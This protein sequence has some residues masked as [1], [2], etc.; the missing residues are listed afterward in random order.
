M[1]RALINKTF[2]IRDGEI[3]ISFLMQL[4]IFTI[5]TVLLMVKPT[6]NALFLSNLGADN[7]P[8]GYLLVAFVAV[9]TTYFYNKLVKRFS[10]LKI[11]SISLVIFSVSFLVLSAVLD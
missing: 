3:Y 5:I 1:L 10:L 9:I 6:V 2:G 8:Y 7:L 11:T 4:Y